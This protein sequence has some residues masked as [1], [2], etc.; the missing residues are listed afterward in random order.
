MLQPTLVRIGV[1]DSRRP[2]VVASVP[3]RH[4]GA[5][6]RLWRGLRRTLLVTGTGFLVGNVALVMVPI[7]HVHLCLLPLSFVFGPIFGAFAWRDRALLGAAAVDCPRCGQQATVPE[8]LA[9]WP[10]RFNCQHCHIMVE[11]NPARPRSA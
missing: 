2:Q 8:R 6:A 1:M 9:G 5:A 10:A 4:L 3:A 11:L 7:P